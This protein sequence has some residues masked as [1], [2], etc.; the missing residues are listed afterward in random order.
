MRRLT[1][2]LFLLSIF[3]FSVS[4]LHAADADAV[5][6]LKGARLIDGTGAPPLENAVIVIKGTK[7]TA[8]GPADKVKV[9]KN[10][11][12]VDVTGRTIIP[13]LFSAHSHVGVILHGQNREDAYTRDNVLAQ[14][15]QYEQYGVTSIVALGTNRDLIYE[16][17][18]EQRAGKLGGATIFSGDRGYGVPG[19]AP[20]LRLAPDQVYRPTSPEQARQLVDEAAARHPDI[21]KVWVDDVFGQMKKMDPAIYQAVIDEGH[22][23]H[24]KVAAHVFYL[25][26]A[27]GLVASNIDVLAHSVRD[28]PVDQ[29]LIAMMKA[30]GTY[31]IPTFTV[32]QSFYYFADRSDWRQDSFLMAGLTPEVKTLFSAPDYKQ[33]VDANPIVAQCRLAWAQAMKNYKT[34]HDAG[35]KLAFGTDS[36]ANPPSRVPGFAEHNELEMMVQAGI[37][38]MEAL[39]IATHGSASLIGA[40]DRGTIVKGKRADLIVLAANPLDNISNTKTMVTIYHN[41]REVKPRA[42]TKAAVLGEPLFGDDLLQGFS[43]ALGHS[44]I[45]D[46]CE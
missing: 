8:V 7:I 45:E 43:A 33:K 36:G 35:I 22:K 12:V 5:T 9:P 3:T 1:V 30:K 6:V 46:V 44:P 29:E 40:K 17:R 25:A 11:R 39:T 2:L 37:T 4:W 31:Y 20:P 13:G 19:G 41:G 38:P 42:T 10:A 23:H 28:L 34:L 32:D 26:D 15:D 18:A 14:L 16:I 21:L 24:L 27:K